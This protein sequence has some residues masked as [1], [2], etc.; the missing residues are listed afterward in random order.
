MIKRGW[1]AQAIPQPTQALP[2]A[3][4]TVLAKPKGSS[5]PV[6]GWIGETFYMNGHAL[7]TIVVVPALEQL[8]PDTLRTWQLFDAQTFD[9]VGPPDSSR[10]IGQMRAKMRKRAMKLVGPQPL[11]GIVATPSSAVCRGES[12]AHNEEL[13]VIRSAR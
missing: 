1:A 11:P 5:P 10:D 9:P 2:E 8:K 4:K 3:V 7:Y 6:G 12:G 13:P